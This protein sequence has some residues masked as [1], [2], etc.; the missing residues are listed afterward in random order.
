M[1]NRDPGQGVER[2]GAASFSP[3]IGISTSRAPTQSEQATCAEWFLHCCAAPK[4]AVPEAPGIASEND[5]QARVRGSQISCLTCTKTVCPLIC[6]N[7]LDFHLQLCFKTTLF[8][9]IENLRF[10]QCLRLTPALA[11]REEFTPSIN[12]FLEK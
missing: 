6:F 8:Y 5:G 9:K 4:G 3:P 1:G 10:T 7:S 11:L 12:V 2:A